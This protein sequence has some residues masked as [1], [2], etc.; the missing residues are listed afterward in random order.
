VVD[1]L[2]GVTIN[3]PAPVFDNGF[4]S[5]ASDSVHLRVYFP[6]GIQH[7]DGNE[8]LTYARIGHV[9]GSSVYART[10]RQARQ[11]VVAL[12]AAGQLQRTSPPTLAI[13]WIRWARPFH[14]DI[15]EGPDVLGPMIQLA[16]TIKADDIKSYVWPRPTPTTRQSGPP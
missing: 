14:T 13:W 1:T 15:P 11:V 7:M 4:P 9:L 16:E 12:G 6:A 10:I 5:N 2:G 8:A 3:V